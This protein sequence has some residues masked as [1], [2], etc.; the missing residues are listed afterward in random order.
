MQFQPETN[1]FV[2]VRESVCLCVCCSCFFFFSLVFLLVTRSKTLG[3]E[4]K[5]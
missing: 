1:E 5:I 3:K 4:Q 2:Y